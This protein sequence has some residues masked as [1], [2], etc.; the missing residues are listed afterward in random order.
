MILFMVEMGNFHFLTWAENRE[1]AKSN[2]HSWI[3]SRKDYYTVTPLT[4]KGDRVTIDRIV[5]SS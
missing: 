3:G 5:L 1:R 2:A 4:E